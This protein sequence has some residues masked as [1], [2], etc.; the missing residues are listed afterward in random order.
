MNPGRSPR[1]GRTR[2]GSASRS[3]SG[4]ETTTHAT[5]ATVAVDRPVPTIRTLTDRH[6]VVET[7]RLPGRLSGR[8][9]EVA[10]GRSQE[11]RRVQEGGQSFVLGL[12][13]DAEAGRVFRELE[14]PIRAQECRA[15]TKAGVRQAAHGPAV[16]SVE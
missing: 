13:R 4:A 5:H 2:A 11:C 10:S 9:M 14:R 15:D 6:P 8:Q 16:V 1:L 3:I 12:D 7:V